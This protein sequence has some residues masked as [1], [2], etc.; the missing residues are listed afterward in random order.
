MSDSIAPVKNFRAQREAFSFAATK[1]ECAQ[2]IERP[3]Q[4]K[5]IECPPLLGT[6]VFGRSGL[7]AERDCQFALLFAVRR[8][9]NVAD[10]KKRDPLCASPDV[11][12]DSG[13]QTRNQSRSQ[14]DMI[15]T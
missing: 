12:L 11:S 13:K 3:S 1:F 2:C 5:E 6:P 9:K 15:F 10:F 4:I 7:T 8:G 14:R